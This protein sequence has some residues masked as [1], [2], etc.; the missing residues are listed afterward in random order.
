MAY[1]DFTTL[2][3]LNQEIGIKHQLCTLFSHPIK[4]VIPSSHLVFDLEEAEIL[5]PVTEKSKSELIISPILKEVRR[6]NAAKIA[7]FSGISFDVAPERNLNGICDFMFGAAPQTLEINAPVLCI[8]EAKNRT[9][10]E[11]FAQCAAEMYAAQLYNKQDLLDIP[12]VYGVVTN[13]YDWAFMSL[14]DTT[15]QIDTNRYTMLK[16]PELLGVFQI[17]INE[18]I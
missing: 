15:L 16:L 3:K 1:S 9:L 8:I 13:G 2:R 5:V 18:M 11:G 14:Q 12:K 7:Y 4:E 10:E 6:N 17:T